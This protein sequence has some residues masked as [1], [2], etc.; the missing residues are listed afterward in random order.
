MKDELRAYFSNLAKEASAR[1]TPEQRS[2]RARHAV[3][4]RWAKDSNR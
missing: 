1:M 4:A 2:E 3:K